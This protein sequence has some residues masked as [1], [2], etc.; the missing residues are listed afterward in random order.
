MSNFIVTWSR[1]YTN[2]CASPPL[3]AMSQTPHK[4]YFRRAIDFAIKEHIR[5]AIEER[6]RKHR[7]LPSNG[8]AALLGINSNPNAH[9][10]A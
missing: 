5:S 4:I 2:Q 8:N 6:V 3:P 1:Q 7:S 10:N 9:E